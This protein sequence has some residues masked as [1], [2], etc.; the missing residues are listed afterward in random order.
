[1]IPLVFIITESLQ[2]QE[3]GVVQ[4]SEPKPFLQPEINFLA[5]EP[6][7]DGV[8][9]VQLSK[10]PK[11]KFN[12]IAKD[13]PQNP[14][15]VE[16]NYRL[17]YGTHFLYLYIE[18]DTDSFI[19]RDRGFQ[20]GDGFTVAITK[21]RPENLPTDEYYVLGFSATKDKNTFFRKVVWHHNMVFGFKGLSNET[22]FEIKSDKNKVGFELLLPWSEVYPYHPWISDGI[23]FNMVFVKAI[24]TNDLNFHTI[25]KDGQR[26][27]GDNQRKRMY[28]NL[29]FEK[30][31][32]ERSDQTYM[33]MNRNCIFGDSI[34][35]KIAAV[36]A[37]PVIEKCQLLIKKGE[38]NRVKT[39]N[40][41][42]N[43]NKGLTINEYNVET[44]DLIPGDYQVEWKSKN[45]N[46]S[47]KS[48]LTIMP[49]FNY[50][51][52]KKQ[53]KTICS[54][55]SLG[56]CNTLQFQLEQIQSQFKR[57]KP[58][59]ICPE[60]CK[61][62]TSFLE[63]TEKA[64]KGEDA[65]R[66][67][68]GIFRRAFRSKIDGTLQ[69]YSIK[70]PNDFDLSKKYSLLVWLH[71]SDEDDQGQL[72]NLRSINNL[73]AI[74]PCGRGKRHA[75]TT[76][77]SQIDI[78]EAINDVV[79]NYPIDTTN[80][81]LA[82]FSMGGYGVYRTFFE[83]PDRYK[84]LAVFSGQPDLATEYFPE[85]DHPNFLKERYLTP[86]KKTPVFIAHGKKDNNT[87][88]HLTQEV[89]KKLD[90]LGAKVEFNIDEEMGH[91]TSEKTWNEFYKWIESF[92]NKN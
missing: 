25:I 29:N 31:E 10:L 26:Y 60:L 87:P 2:A 75:Y 20:N 9:D 52:L 21:P 27:I 81:I 63:H 66:T 6:I 90:S 89:V 14:A 54:N 36:S 91:G 28:V 30:P 45:G 84:A 67:K 32:L 33:A 73:I 46:Y 57:L 69:P 70:I 47:G 11:R 53:L 42:Y 3:S 49:P 7:I 65:Y 41:E 15:P 48:E 80:I 38:G 83:T 44:S 62:L 4:L 86:L 5:Q 18:V 43:C 12:F 40:I 37:N 79:L 23:G 71:G 13:N 51:T 74:A 34:K 72:N 56:G 22:K 85:E 24:G 1:V 17:A 76:S 64:K 55:I 82:G 8:L 16:I 68:I 59:D 39:E 19:C 58:Y 92:G 77:E 35:L 61:R 88:F 78:Q 50:D